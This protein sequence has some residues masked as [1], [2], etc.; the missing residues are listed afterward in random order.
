MKKVIIGSRGSELA[1]WQ[2]NYILAKLRELGADAQ[3]KTIKTR[4][5]LIP[6]TGFDK[7][8]GKGFFTKEIEDALLK[9]EIDLAVHSHKDLPT[10]LP[11]GLM[12][13]AVSGREDPSEL[14]LIN[15]EAADER[16][17]FSLRTGAVVGTSS[18]R[19]KSQLLA[20]R[21]DVVIK[22]LRGN[23]PTRIRKLREKQY[24]AILIAAA[25]V[26]RLEIDLA[27]FIN[28]KLS[29]KEFIPAPAQGVLA[30]EM[31][32]G[33]KELAAL[34][35]ELNDVSVSEAISIERKVLNL[36]DGGCQL[37]LG[38][39]CEKDE[40]EG[41]KILFKVW[42]AKAE[43]GTSL[44]KYFYFE[45]KQADGLAEKIAEK[46]KN[47]KPSPVFITRNPR[48]HDL[49]A[50]ILSG[51]GYRVTC[52]TLIEIKPLP[53]KNIPQTEWVFFSSKHAVKYFFE[54]KPD[55][56]GKKFGAVG[57]STA[58]ELRSHGVRADFIGYSADTRLTG[59]QFA[60]VA[61]NKTVLFPQAK[62]SM[63][64]IQQQFP[65]KEKVFDIPVYETIYQG[66]NFILP[67]DTGILVF[68]SPS[69]VEAFFRNGKNKIS[70]QQKVI[71]MGG[72][73][74]HTLRKTG[75]RVSK[76]PP[77]FDD[78]GLLQAVFSL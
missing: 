6:D 61:G 75:A 74:A 69:N 76:E 12:I 13:A 11:D 37:P 51:H 33:E 42:A 32:A 60:S 41:G 2:A 22:E 63:R 23:V 24:D 40:D 17:K 3:L 55:I 64:S 28:E 7:M 57:K 4:G 53:V 65:K 56:D 9:K 48:K 14:L 26:N 38:V 1:L 27:E 62:E 72:A 59:K 35:S 5:D 45:S 54:L 43:T 21:S 70:P 16:K 77:S 25:G 78:M 50:D 20:L 19:R 67:P 68:T 66:E 39:Y 29:P 31:R 34:L 46:I 18:V 15:K 10:S 30:L 36:F 8:E 47:V 71:A 73:T 44:P 52:K 58:A 49:F